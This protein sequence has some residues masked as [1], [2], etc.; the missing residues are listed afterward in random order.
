MTRH[1]EGQIYSSEGNE[2]VRM[3]E[4]RSLG[5]KEPLSDSQGDSPPGGETRGQST[6]FGSSLIG[7]V[8]RS[9]TKTL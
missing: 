4:E 8:R 9:L 2:S 7:K 6:N 1:R 3:D 5:G